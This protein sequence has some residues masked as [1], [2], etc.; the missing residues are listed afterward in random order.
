[1]KGLQESTASHILDDGGL[2]LHQILILRFGLGPHSHYVASHL[3]RHLR[4]DC[5]GYDA[6]TRISS[7]GVALHACSLPLDCIL[8]HSQ[9]GVGELPTIKCFR[10]D[11]KVRSRQVLEAFLVHDGKVTGA[12]E[13]SLN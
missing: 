8:S 3:W 2:L 6:C 1:M 12:S 7:H 4:Y 5:C 11:L 10:V 9:N 13:S